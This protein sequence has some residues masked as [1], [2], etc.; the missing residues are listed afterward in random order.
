V[1]AAWWFT[2]LIALVGVERIAELVVS[3]RN[4]AWSMARGGREYGQG[5]FPP[6]VVLHTGLL[7]GALVEVWVADRPFVPEL[8]WPML[9]V[10]VAAQGLRWWCIGTLGRRWNTRIIIVPGLP[11]VGAGPYRFLR[12]PNYV[13]VVLE[14]IALPLVGTAWITALVFTLLNAALLKVRITAENRA[15]AL[16]PAATSSAG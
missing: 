8:G 16:L 12:H 2:V 7:A 10:V 1:S 13:A 6:M 14:G 11:L 4:A 15:L 5:H 9:A 3:T